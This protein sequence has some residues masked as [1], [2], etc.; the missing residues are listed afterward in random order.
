MRIT[1][2]IRFWDFTSPS[3]CFTVTGLDPAQPKSIFDCPKMNA[4]DAVQTYN[5]NINNK[6]FMCYVADTPSS[7]KILPAHLPIKEGRGLNA[8]APSYS[9]V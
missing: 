1:I 9:N 4:T 3:K 6:L 7:D 8:V 5:N 2:T